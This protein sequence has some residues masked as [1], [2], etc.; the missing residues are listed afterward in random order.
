[1]KYNII[2]LFIFLTFFSFINGEC[3]I[4][5]V[6]SCLVEVKHAN[7]NL[8]KN[9]LDEILN[10]TTE[11]RLI[12]LCRIYEKTKPC[13]K[14]KMH[15]CASQRQIL[16]L[17]KIERYYKRFCSKTSLPFQKILYKYGKCLKYAIDNFNEDNCNITTLSNI[18]IQKCEQF[19][20]E[21]D[22][23][24]QK[25]IDDSKYR[26][27]EH[28]FVTEQCGL[29]ASQ[30][31]D[32]LKSSEIDE[33]YPINCNYKNNTFK[34]NY[35]KNI[36]KKKIVNKRISNNIH[37]IFKSLKPSEVK[38][39]IT[40]TTKK[41]TLNSILTMNPYHEAYVP[42][43]DNSTE[44]NNTKT[45]PTTK[46]SSTKL[47]L[48]SI[49]E[50]P[51]TTSSIIFPQIVTSSPETKL[52]FPNFVNKKPYSPTQNLKT[53]QLNTNY[54]SSLPKNITSKP[55]FYVKIKD[56]N[57]LKQFKETANTYVSTALDVI[58][59]KTQD[60]VKNAVVREVFA[61]ILRL[62]PQILNQT[63]C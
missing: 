37:E 32:M 10:V 8:N 38:S 9:V 44:S 54:E 5:D 43:E 14:D 35:K 21:N 52:I 18:K 15:S 20:D 40:T 60:F 1:M 33:E 58:A 16:F 3:N 53:P 61:T 23:D 6:T 30:F 24:C 27:C 56:N 13:F 2:I 7:I 12:R 26:L 41:T 29:Q 31:F 28:N 19:C 47:I 22:N 39:N 46:S 36:K 50:V 42:F 49:T 17:E 4:H 11:A 51:S 55:S 45:V 25:K 62:S 48:S 63:N 59:D 34:K 57:D